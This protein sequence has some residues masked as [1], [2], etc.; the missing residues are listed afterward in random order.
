M[1]RW[2]TARGVGGIFFPQ[3]PVLKLDGHGYS[4]TIL[5]RILHIASVTSAFEVAE[6]ALKVVG[7]ISISARQINNLANEIGQELAADRDAKTEQYVSAPLPRQPTTVDVQPD[8]AAVFFD[9]GR[10]RTREPDQGRGVHQPHWRETK[11]AGFHR[12]KSETF[13]EDP[14]PELPDCFRNEAYV[15]KLVKGL[16]SLKTEGSEEDLEAEQPSP[17]STAPAEPLPQDRASWQPETLFHTCLSS[18]ASSET[19]GPMMAAEADARGFFTAKKKAFLGD[20]QCYNWTIQQRWFADFVP[21][22][23]FVHAVEYVYTAAK[24]VHADAPSRWHQYLEWATACWKGDTATVIRDLRV[25]QSRLGI[26]AEGEKVSDTDPRKIIHSVTTYFTNSG[27]RMDYP[28]YRQKGLPV[29]SSL[30]ESLVKQISKRVKGTEKFWN[31]GPS[32]EA[33][34]QL[35]AAVISDGDRLQRWMTNRPVSPFS[36][37]CRTAVLANAT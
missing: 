30:A 21:I 5:H 12:M 9:G 25:W 28:R 24:T 14:Q 6:T 18:L 35:R 27:A 33:I 16:K 29:T 34:L 8:L 36:P 7:E 26:L 15:E 31:D 20:G 37:R 11:N 32:G 3:R 22:A 4:P 1:N 10:M 13:S 23:D 2:A 17:T 19:F